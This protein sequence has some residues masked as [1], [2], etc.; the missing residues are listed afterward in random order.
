MSFPRRSSFSPGRTHPPSPLSQSCTSTSHRRSSSSSVVPSGICAGFFVAS[1]PE[2]PLSPLAVSPST[3]VRPRLRRA[4]VSSSSTTTIQP[5]SQPIP[6]SPRS[7]LHGSAY[8]AQRQSNLEWALRH[9]DTELIR[10]ERA[11]I[12]RYKQAAAE[13]AGF[14][15]DEAA[16]SD[17][18]ASVESFEIPI[19]DTSQAPASSGVR[20]NTGRRMSC[21]ATY[22]GLPAPGPQPGEPASYFV[23]LEGGYPH[24]LPASTSCIVGTSP[25][26]G[27]G[28][29]FYRPPSPYRSSSG[30]VPLS[31]LF[32]PNRRDSLPPLSPTRPRI[33]SSISDPTGSA[34][35][36][37]PR[38][39]PEGGA[40]DA[41]PSFS[42]RRESAPNS[43]LVSPTTRIIHG[44]HIDRPSSPPRSVSPSAQSASSPSPAPAPAHEISRGRAGSIASFVGG[45]GGGNS[46]QAR[47]ELQASRDIE[48]LEGPTPAA[49]SGAGAA[50]ATAQQTSRTAT[51]KTRNSSRTRRRGRDLGRGAGDPGEEHEA[52]TGRSRDGRAAAAERLRKGYNVAREEVA[53]RDGNRRR[54]SRV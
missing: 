35:L 42:S 19:R 4:S 25:V 13:V 49:A 53:G 17:G 23:A 10:T 45:L 31:P 47:M 2:S 21:L 39:S 37:R 6:I 5:P 48:V 28:S 41:A 14:H 1:S 22:T 54:N 43:T 30:I 18:T 40:D 44:F 26:S 46:Q 12:E 3:T 7:S 32:D 50:G 51:R 15:L 11:A 38:A 16:T 52:R 20:Y 27:G 36:H 9:N 33:P 34:S 8:L 29:G 24:A